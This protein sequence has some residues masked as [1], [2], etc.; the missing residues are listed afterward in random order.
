L[1]STGIKTNMRETRVSPSATTS[2]DNPILR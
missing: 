1:I 2:S